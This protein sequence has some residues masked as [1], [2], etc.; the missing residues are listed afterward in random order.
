MSTTRAT[1]AATHR[2]VIG[3]KVAGLRKA[4]QVPGV[5]FGHGRESSP[6]SLDAREFE[7]LWRKAGSNTLVN[8]AID[9]KKPVPV[10]IHSIQRHP[11]Q[12]SLLHVDL[13]AVR[14]TEEI[15]VD[16]PLVTIGESVAVEKM[17]GTLLHI[18]EHVRVKALPDHLPHSIEVSI[19][20]LVDF[21]TIIH[22]ADLVIPA[23]VTLV[24]DPHDVVARVQARR[25]EEAPAAE[26]EV[27]AA[28]TEAEAPAG[29]STEA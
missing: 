4:G 14:M 18:L 26:E 9:G 25:A 29:A 28:P 8:L 2:D 17:G 27:A 5:V 16:I 12:Q 7:H 6:V 24:N 15:T 3:K 21:D 10:V 22:V 11:V 20:S 1:L 19:D 23:G 13:F